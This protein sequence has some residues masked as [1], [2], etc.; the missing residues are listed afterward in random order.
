VKSGCGIVLLLGLS[1]AC[2]NSGPPPLSQTIAGCPQFLDLSLVTTGTVFKA[3][4]TGTAHGL[5]LSRGATLSVQ[6]TECDAECQWCSFDGPVRGAGPPIA[7]RCLND[8]AT[9]CAKD[10]D[11]ASGPCR[12]L[13]PP[14]SSAIGGLDTCTVPFFESV[15]GPDTSPVQ[16][17]VNLATGEVTMT[18]INLAI[19]L[20]G[21]HGS[22][23]TCDQCVGDPMPNDGAKGGTCTTTNMPCDK[24]GDAIAG[25]PAET[26][27]D[28]VQ[29]PLGVPSFPLSAGSP[30]TLTTQWTMD[31]T[32][33]KCT[34]SGSS[35]TS[36]CWC[37]ICSDGTPCTENSE[38][39]DNVC[40]TPSI[41]SAQFNVENN[42]C[43]SAGCNWNATTN[44]GACNG[45]GTSCFP[46]TG[47]MF[48][49]GSAEVHYV[50]GGVYYISQVASLTC[51]PSFTLASGP[52]IGAMFDSVSGF[53]G[54]ILFQARFQMNKRTGP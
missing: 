34:A 42:S 18:V 44:S 28:C 12:F 36:W 25:T 19:D 24:N 9:V 23:G 53:P 3:G 27:W 39:A 43:G 48:A 52:G 41:G 38:C 32:R 10:S 33:P 5:G 30:S 11:C 21:G 50:P 54:P 13:W 35:L 31:A 17:V 40:G 16:G 26:S 46:D 51:V 20:G 45:T 2:N 37:G 4:W 7:Q 14:V 49:E 47:S 6:I 8:T 1:A 22:N 15:T 29:V